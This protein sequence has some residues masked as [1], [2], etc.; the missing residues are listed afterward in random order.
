MIRGGEGGQNGNDDVT[1]MWSHVLARKT[2]RPRLSTKQPRC[3]S[4]QS[5]EIFIDMEADVKM[6]ETTKAEPL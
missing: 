1:K 5:E 4:G 2:V 3:L 6:T